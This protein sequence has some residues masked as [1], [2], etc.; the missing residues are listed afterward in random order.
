[1][2]T[3]AQEQL[4]GRTVPPLIGGKAQSS[5][6]EH[7]LIV[8]DDRFCRTD[9]PSRWWMKGDP[10]ATAWFNSVSASLPRGEAFFI[11]TMKKFRDEIPPGLA[12]EVRDFI[13]QEINHTREHVAFNRIIA[14]HGYDVES[15][16][17]GIADMLSLAEGRP[18][19]VNLAVSIALEHFAASI[20]HEL[21]ADPSYLAGAEHEPA[22][23]W[24]WHAAEEIE[25]KGLVFE[26]W[27]HVTRDWSAGK[28][29]KMMAL[30]ALLITRKY[31][32]NRVRDALGLM[33]QDG[34]TGWRARARL[35]W[36]LWG[37]P[38]MIRRLLPHWG[39]I[40]LPGFKPWDL[41]NSSLI[42]LYRQRDEMAALPLVQAE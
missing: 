5:P 36:Y 6:E 18:R 4:E 31:F 10:V 26:V 9:R 37:N 28:R 17:R 29:W 42:R 3:R 1:M 38:G 27:L 21:L 33:A 23:L 30:V 13:R 32:G 19:E 24:R 20:S 8:R 14:D 11:D 7:G 15:I 16:E 25:H 39:R 12:T 40:L 2:V 41:D 22:E 34:L 35:Y